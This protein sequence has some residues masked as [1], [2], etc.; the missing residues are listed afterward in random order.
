M[1]S[2]SRIIEHRGDGV[3]QGQ[4]IHV[5]TGGNLGF[6]LFQRCRLTIE[7]ISDDVIEITDESETIAKERK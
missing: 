6:P 3:F 7:P 1:T 4:N 5:T 2:I